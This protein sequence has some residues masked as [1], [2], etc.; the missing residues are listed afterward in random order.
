MTYERTPEHRAKRAE[1]I[2]RWKPWEKSTGPRTIEGKRSSAMRGYKG[3]QR[4]EL[5]ALAKELREIQR[6]L[7]TK[8]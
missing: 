6:I 8:V 1:M 4:D 5:R 3:G 2:K 7:D